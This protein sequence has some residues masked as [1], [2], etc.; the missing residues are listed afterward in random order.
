MNN[1]EDLTYGYGPYRHGKHGNKMSWESLLF[2]EELPEIEKTYDSYDFLRDYSSVHNL[3]S[4]STPQPNPFSNKAMFIIDKLTKMGV[5][6]TVDI[7][8]YDGNNVMWGV[9]ENS[10]HKLINIIAEPNPQVAGPAIVF[11]AHHDVM[12]VHSSNCQ[13]NGAS[14]CNLLKL[15]SIIKDSPA[16]SNRT[17]ILFSDCEESGARGAKQFAKNSKKNNENP[18]I[19][20]HN[21]YGQINAVINLELTGNGS[22]IW[23][24]C[25]AKKHEIELHEKLEHILGESIP[26]LNTPPSDAIAF[27]QYNYPVLCI[28][29]L[30]EDD[31]KQK[32]TWRICHS[33]KDTIDGCNRKNMEDFT[34]FL[35]S[36]TK[37]TTTEHGN[38][39]GANKTGRSM[40]T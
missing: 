40:H 38:H 33:L 2:L 23:S 18:S 27:R 8:T 20:D 22:V 39:T 19:I 10:T 26:K 5:K 37:T 16:N 17:I 15:A 34:K 25:E 24:D 35:L 3:F 36:I 1:N 32:E 28:G 6:Y 29:I 13:D 14:V 4:A 7:F 31:M 30:P 9:G 21:T 12:N 11:C